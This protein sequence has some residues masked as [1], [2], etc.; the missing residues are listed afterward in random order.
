[1]LRINSLHNASDYYTKSLS[2]GDYYSEGGEVRGEWK[3]L[4]C[5]LLKLNGTVNE[6]DFSLLCNNINP[7][8]LNQLSPRQNDNRRE[9]YDFTFSVPK[10][11]SIQQAISKDDRILDVIKSSVFETMEYVESDIQTRVRVDGLNE[12]RVTSN[13]SYAYFLH[14]NSRPVDGYSDPHLHIHAVVMNLTYDFEEHKW[15]AIEMRDKFEN[16]EYFQGIFNSKVANK[17]QDLGYQ[18]QK[19]SNNFELVGFDTETIKQFSRRTTQIN[20]LAYSKNIK[21][22]DTK[23]EL[24]ARTRSH[25]SDKLSQDDLREKYLEILKPEDKQLIENTFERSKSFEN[26]LPFQIDQNTNPDQ[27]QKWLDYTL[28]KTFERHSTISEKRLI[29]EVLIYGIG[30]TDVRGIESLI[31]DYKSEGI[32]IP[33]GTPRSVLESRVNTSPSITT[34]RALSEE[35]SIVEIINSQKLIHNPIN[36]RYAQTILSDTFL[37]Q[38]QKDSVSS[39]LLSRDGV[40]LLEGKAGTGKT[41]VLKSIE[42]GCNQNNVDVLVLAPTTKAVDVLKSEGFI[43]ATTI[44]KYLS[45]KDLQTE[46]KNKYIIVDEASLVSARQMNSFLNIAKENQNRVLLVGDTK[47]HKSVE[48]GNNLKT[49]QDHSKIQTTSLS[50]ILRQHQE[51]SKLAVELLSNGKTLKGL[52]IFEKLNYIKEI[53]DDK[54][55]LNN[56]AS[57]YLTYLTQRES[58]QIITPIHSDGNL[59]HNTIRESLKQNNLIDN[60]DHIYQTLRPLSLTTAE[61]S[62]TQNFQPNQIIQI[63]QNTEHFKKGDRFTVV[64]NESINPNSMQNTIQSPTLLMQDKQGNIYP[65]PT[66]KPNHFEV[67]RSVEI[68]LSKGDKIQ[69][70]KQSQVYDTKWKEHKT[71]NGSYYT[72]KNISENGN[73]ILNNNW[74]I[75]KDFGNLKSGYYTTSYSSQGSTVDHSIFYTSNISLPLLNQ[76]LM[77]VANSRFKKTNLILTPN[78]QELKKYAQNQN[79]APLALDLTT[80]TKSK[81]TPQISLQN[82]QQIQNNPQVTPNENTNQPSNKYEYAKM[83]VEKIKGGEVVIEKTQVAITEKSN[84]LKL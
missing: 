71:N 6:K 34:E 15:K 46:S 30:S 83:M 17:L 4:A 26:P 43:S 75:P 38:N 79:T 69:I 13:M 47:Q 53:P 49:I 39:I 65:I 25:K 23:G 33:E 78:I 37:N 52:E 14:K 76:D 16:R 19:T 24:G 60:Q 28:E 7:H 48:R 10:S 50:K 84:K 51:D 5:Q 80:S 21:D 2:R 63:T 42:S 74:I 9:A 40:N 59:I 3:G 77:Y 73:L 57:T 55:R 18:I 29:G 8:N 20:E 32:L 64:N 58:V 31:E 36:S 81:Q 45:D 62:E 11:V 70:L 41:T 66:H 54:E 22:V 68:K 67:Y 35:R 27:N 1:M 82:P 61:K 72:I 44:Q 12:N 56:L